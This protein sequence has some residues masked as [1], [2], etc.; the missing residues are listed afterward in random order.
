MERRVEGKFAK[1]E[2]SL[3]PGSQQLP[4]PN[5]GA[6]GKAMPLSTN[7][8]ISGMINMKSYRL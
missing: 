5:A 1:P 7:N 2:I 4:R 8:G 3:L 6:R